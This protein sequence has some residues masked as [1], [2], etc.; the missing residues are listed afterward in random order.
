MLAKE[1]GQGM[2]RDRTRGQ[3]I[4]SI[5]QKARVRTPAFARFQSRAWPLKRFC[6][7]I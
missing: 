5:S 6:P 4:R 3:M 7:S 1:R 2:S